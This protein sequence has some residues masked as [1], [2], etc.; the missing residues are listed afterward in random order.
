MIDEK[1][2][3]LL[4]TLPVIENPQDIN[5]QSLL[6]KDLLLAGFPARSFMFRY[7]EIF[8]VDISRF[9]FSKYFSNG[10][11]S[12][13]LYRYFFKRLKTPLSMGDLQQAISYGVLNEKVLRDI[14]SKK[15][16]KSKRTKI[17]LKTS[18]QFISRNE[19]IMYAL[20]CGALAIILATVA[21][22]F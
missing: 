18:R 10:T 12:D 16:G 4:P 19:G 1:L 20:L 13:K 3:E 5:E 9:Y 21:F 7:S 22:L 2:I 11:K 15:A 17:R 6:E 8:N 14:N